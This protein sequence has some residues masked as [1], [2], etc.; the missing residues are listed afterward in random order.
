MVL[1]APF[2]P[3]GA[4][5]VTLPSGQ[6]GDGAHLLS[7]IVTEH[8]FLAFIENS[9]ATS[10]ISENTDV[11]TQKIPCVFLAVNCQPFDTLLFDIYIKNKN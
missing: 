4:L 9:L 3:T 11:L 1:C 10:L 2:N 5:P 6:R 7:Q 8:R